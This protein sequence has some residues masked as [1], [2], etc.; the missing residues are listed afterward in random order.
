MSGPRGIKKF[1]AYKT[2]VCHPSKAQFAINGQSGG[3]PC[4]KAH[5]SKAV[6]FAIL[7]PEVARGTA[8][9]LR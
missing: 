7:P 6:F 1:P 3:H 9:A 8:I 4:D 5:L 2:T